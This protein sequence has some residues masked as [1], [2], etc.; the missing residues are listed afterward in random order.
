MQKKCINTYNEPFGVK[1]WTILPPFKKISSTAFKTKQKSTGDWI[2]LF[3][4]FYVLYEYWLVYIYIYTQQEAAQKSLP[5]RRKFSHCSLNLRLSHH[6]CGALPLSYACP[7][8]FF[9][10]AMSGIRE[11]FRLG[12]VRTLQLQASLSN[13][14]SPNS[15]VIGLNVS[16]LADGTLLIHDLCASVSPKLL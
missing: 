1:I 11:H 12:S 7:H 10:A 4:R 15:V 3:D 13:T 14:F 5:W 2:Y 8:C 16:D 9:P 6:K